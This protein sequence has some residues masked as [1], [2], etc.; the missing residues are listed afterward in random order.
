[1]CVGD[2][3][4][5]AKQEV[6]GQLRWE[7]YTTRNHAANL[8]VIWKWVVIAVRILHVKKQKFK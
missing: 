8:H 1:M 5:Q 6:N 2:K 4:D 7:A 3:D